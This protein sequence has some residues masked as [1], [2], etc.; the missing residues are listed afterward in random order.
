MRTFLVENKQPGPR[1]IILAALTY[2]HAPAAVNALCPA[3][4]T[5]LA[6][7]LGS[8]RSGM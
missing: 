5:I 8:H 1:D 3:L 6:F 2:F 4:V 7:G